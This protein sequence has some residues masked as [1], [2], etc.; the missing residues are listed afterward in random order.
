M[1]SCYYVCPHATM[2]PHT[3]IYV[4]SYCYI[5][6]M[7]SAGGQTLLACTSQHVHVINVKMCQ[8]GGHSSKRGRNSARCAEVFEGQLLLERCTLQSEVGSGLIVADS[9]SATV[10]ECTSRNC[11][12]CG[13][14]VFDG[15]TLLCN[16]SVISGNL[17]LLY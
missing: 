1:S 14:L 16:D 10:K 12:K 4:S 13:L 6:V 2:C 15:G 11:G 8:T 5:S 7:R 9:G 17:C 3:T